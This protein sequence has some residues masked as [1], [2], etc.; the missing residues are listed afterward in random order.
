MSYYALTNDVKGLDK[1][2]VMYQDGAFAELRATRSKVLSDLSVEVSKRSALSPKTAL[3]M[4][5]YSLGNYAGSG[6]RQINNFLEQL[7][8]NRIERGSIVSFFSLPVQVLLMM[9][10]QQRAGAKQPVVVFRG[11]TASRAQ[12]GDL[13][14]AVQSLKLDAAAFDSAR[15]KNQFAKLLQPGVPVNQGVYRVRSYLQPKKRVLDDEGEY[16]YVDV[17]DEKEKLAAQEK[18]RPAALALFKSPAAFSTAI[19]F[20]ATDAALLEAS[21]PPSTLLANQLLTADVGQRLTFAPFSSASFNQNIARGFALK[22]QDRRSVADFKPGTILEIALPAGMPCVSMTY[23]Y[24]QEVLLPP[25][26][27]WSSRASRARSAPASKSYE[28]SP[29][30][31]QQRPLR[32]KRSRC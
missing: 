24:E 9:A 19:D 28:P 29:S 20:Y 18:L 22:G 27:P 6:Y 4:L 2:T 10:I 21:P 5:E 15:A 25:C 1:G 7:S 26:T 3:A 11:V 14:S 16:V 30:C 31:Q 23:G 12:T 17:T 32:S 8:E 13:K